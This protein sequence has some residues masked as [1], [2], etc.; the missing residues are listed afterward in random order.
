V[1]RPSA[2][3]ASTSPGPGSWPDSTGTVLTGAD[4]R[5][6]PAIATFCVPAADVA[7]AV[8]PA[9]GLTAA[10]PGSRPRAL[11]SAGVRSSVRVKIPT[12]YR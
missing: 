8:Y 9:T 3:S 12:S 10:T 2:A 6:S 11:S 5:L 1:A 7:F 4:A